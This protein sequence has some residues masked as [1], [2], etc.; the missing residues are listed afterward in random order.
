M[1]VEP[2]RIKKNDAFI[3]IEHKFSKIR[4][5]QLGLLLNSKMHFFNL[6]IC[7]NKAQYVVPIK[8]FKND[9]TSLSMSRKNAIGISFDL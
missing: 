2:S 9:T 1:K 8:I 5:L 3:S 7:E 4:K 6:L